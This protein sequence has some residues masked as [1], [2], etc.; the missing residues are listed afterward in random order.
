MD[1]ITIENETTDELINKVVSCTLKEKVVDTVV[2]EEI[3]IIPKKE[4]VNIVV[5]E[6]SPFS[7]ANINIFSKIIRKFQ[8][9]FNDDNLASD[10]FLTTVK[11][12]SN[13]SRVGI[14]ENHTDNI[15]EVD[16]TNEKIR[17]K[18]DNAVSIKNQDLINELIERS[19]YCKGFPKTAT[20]H[21][22]SQFA[23]GFGHGVIIKII[24]RKCRGNVFKGS[25]YFTF[26]SKEQS[27]HF[28]KLKSV[29]YHGVELERMWEKDFLEEKRKQYEIFQSMKPK[30]K[31]YYSKGYLIK[32]DI[33]NETV[34]LKKIRTACNAFI[35]KLAYIKL[36]EYKKIAWIRLKP[37]KTAKDI[38]EEISYKS[39]DPSVVFSIPEEETEQ[40]V[41]NGMYKDMMNYRRRRDSAYKRNKR[42]RERREKKT[43]K[44]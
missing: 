3:P 28:F 41:L 7:L 24:P 4:A 39:N 22:L 5:K 18:P 1:N 35:W 13:D 15:L 8:Y 42:R 21:E 43:E 25:A 9:Y 30:P 38:L 6:E 37:V 11:I 17:H 40:S 34:N 27:E 44:K 14:S 2:K 23:A 12:K 19:V 29:K 36:V 32:A 10:T 31:T 33:L 20:I 26:N 16:E